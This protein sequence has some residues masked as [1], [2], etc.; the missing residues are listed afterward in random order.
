MLRLDM[1][2]WWVNGT[3]E[4]SSTF[5]ISVVQSIGRSRNVSCGNHSGSSSSGTVM[6]SDRSGGE[7]PPPPP[8]AAGN[9][10]GHTKR[11]SWR[12]SAGNAMAHARGL[13]TL[14][15]CGMRVHPPCPLNAQPWYPHSTCP[16]ALMRPSES[17]T[18]RCGHSSLKTRQAVASQSHQ[19][20]S[21]ISRSTQ[22]CS[23]SLSRS[24]V[25]ATGYHALKKSNCCSDASMH[26]GLASP[27]ASAMPLCSPTPTAA[28]AAAAHTCMASPFTR[29]R[30]PPACAVNM[31]LPATHGRATRACAAHAACPCSSWRACAVCT[32]LPAAHGRA[33]CACVE[34]AGCLCW[35]DG[36][37]HARGHA[38]TLQCASMSSLP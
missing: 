19:T 15:P 34:H 24:C 7:P 30:L 9:G 10:C 1:D 18:N 21:G 17:G 37:P 31:D 3:C 6:M 33:T 22:R 5:S 35:C 38:G 23:F 4:E 26:K 20:S 32:G 13:S 8:S 2:L 25:N 14:P 29:C 16:A 11:R 36:T 27:T 28:S 12:T